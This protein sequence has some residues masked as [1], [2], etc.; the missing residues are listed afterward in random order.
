V[1]G[2]ESQ[3]DTAIG[4]MIDVIVGM[5]DVEASGLGAERVRT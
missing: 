3:L 5:E 4:Q 2:A 1:A